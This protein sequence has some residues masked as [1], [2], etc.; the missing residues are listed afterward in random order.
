MSSIKSKID[1]IKRHRAYKVISNK[2][3]RKKLLRWLKRSTVHAI[4]IAS[5][6][7]LKVHV[8]VGTRD[9]A[10]LGKIYGYFSAAKSALA[11]QNYHADL[12]MEPIF[13]EKRLDIDSELK[14]KT[15]LSIILWRLIAIA[16]TF[17]YLRVRKIIRTP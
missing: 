14:L 4:R 1:D 13:T 11:L 6:K 5:F 7:K 10:T 15:T 3:L 12:T 2:P 17:P 16:A 9:P 8:K